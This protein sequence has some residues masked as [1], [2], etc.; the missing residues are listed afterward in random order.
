M[1]APSV[2]LRADAVEKLFA[3]SVKANRLRSVSNASEEKTE[4]DKQPV[5]RETGEQQSVSRHRCFRGISF[6][7]FRRKLWYDLTPFVTLAAIS[8]ASW[9][10]YWTTRGYANSRIANSRTGRLADWAT[11]GC[12]QWLCVLSFRSF[13]GICETASCPVCDLASLPFRSSGEMQLNYINNWIN[14]TWNNIT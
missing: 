9:Q 5:L 3:H 13:G 2:H 10:G 12:H 7:D 4:N 6:A 1:I 8:G 11:R 14:V